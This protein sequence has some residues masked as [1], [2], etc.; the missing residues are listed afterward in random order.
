MQNNTLK[1]QGPG[2][3]DGAARVGAKIRCLALM[4]SLGALTGCINR[5]PSSITEQRGSYTEV[6]A[7]TDKEELLTNIVRLAY[8]DAPV[9]FQ[10]CTV[11]AAPSLEYG[12][13]SEV[14]VSTRGSV[15]P[16]MI[17]KPKVLVK[18]APTIVY[19]PLLGK[20]FSSEM[21]VPFDLRPSFLMMENGFDFSIVAQLMYKSM[22]GLSNARTATSAQRAEFRRVTDAISRLARAGL[23]SLGTTSE[24][25]KTAADHMVVNFAPGAFETPDGRLVAAL[26][27][28]NT[29]RGS[30]ALR[31][32]VG[33]DP[34]SILITQRSLLAVLGYMSYSVDIPEA[35]RRQAWPAEENRDAEPLMRIRSSKNRPAGADPA[36]FHRGHWFYISSEDLRSRN[37]LFLIRLLFNLQAQTSGSEEKLQL[38]LPVR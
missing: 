22:N 16:S 37:T 9:F 13:E 17:L 32:G 1:T 15:L 38:T 27:R 7:Q 8:L 4:V 10:V 36:V 21:L 12:S 11:T 18:D 34:E 19:Q 20:E 35:Q 26:L 25:L 29:E 24:G 6:L 5:G 30:F 33:E 2:M 28:L 14:N 31:V 23:V 3:N